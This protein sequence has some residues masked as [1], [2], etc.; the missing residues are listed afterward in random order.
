[1]SDP[2]KAHR[3]PCLACGAA[4]DSCE[5]LFDELLMAASGVGC[6][7]DGRS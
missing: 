2:L 5:Q 4:F 3:Y 6:P 7:D 1:M